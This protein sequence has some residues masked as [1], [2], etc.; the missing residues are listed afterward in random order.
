MDLKTGSGITT[1]QVVQEIYFS[2]HKSRILQIHV[3]SRRQEQQSASLRIG[4]ALEIEGSELPLCRPELTIGI[5]SSVISFRNLYTAT[6]FFL[7]IVA[8]VI[9]KIDLDNEY[10]KHPYQSE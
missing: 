10:V 5:F 9:E 1:S 2:I 8:C 6:N 4:K 3:K 7:K